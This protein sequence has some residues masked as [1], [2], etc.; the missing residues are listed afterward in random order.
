MRPL[1]RLIGSLFFLYIGEEKKVG[2]R[3]VFVFFSLSCFLSL[4]LP[5]A[6][7]PKSLPKLSPKLPKTLPKASQTLPKAT[8]D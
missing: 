6:K 8:P 4:F 7:S 2:G 3:R 1:G 5:P